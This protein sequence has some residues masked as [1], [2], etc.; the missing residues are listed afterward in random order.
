MSAAQLDARREAGLA[1][2]DPTHAFSL[3]LSNAGTDRDEKCDPEARLERLET[4]IQLFRGAKAA[5]SG[6]EPMLFSNLSICVFRSCRV[7]NV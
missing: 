5:I 7:I 4:A 1:T 2:T 3:A 6:S